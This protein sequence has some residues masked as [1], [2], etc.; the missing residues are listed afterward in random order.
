MTA[1]EWV[2]PDGPSHDLPLW[3]HHR[4]W[5]RCCSLIPGGGPQALRT[6]AGFRIVGEHRLDVNH[7]SFSAGIAAPRSSQSARGHLLAQAAD[8]I[9]TSL[10]RAPAVVEQ[11]H[12]LFGGFRGGRC[13]SLADYV[14]GQQPPRRCP[15]HANVA[16]APQVRKPCEVQPTPASCRPRGRCRL[17][18]GRRHCPRSAVIGT[19]FVGQPTWCPLRPHH[20]QSPQ[21]SSMQTG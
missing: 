4:W 13:A 1:A 8:A 14:R 20:W 9:E 5:A 6:L 7:R 19:T 17:T 12:R 21:G 16:Y 10:E 15:Q 3:G 2:V 11:W 18:N